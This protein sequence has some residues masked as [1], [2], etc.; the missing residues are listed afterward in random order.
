MGRLLKEECPSIP[1]ANE[2]NK[3]SPTYR[4]RW[5]RESST[6]IQWSPISEPSARC[7]ASRLEGTPKWSTE[8][9]HKEFRKSVSCEFQG[10]LITKTRALCDKAICTCCNQRTLGHSNRKVW[11]RKRSKDTERQQPPKHSKLLSI[12]LLHRKHWQSYLPWPCRNQ[13]TITGG[14]GCNLPLLQGRQLYSAWK[15]KEPTRPGQKHRCAWAVSTLCWLPVELPQ[16]TFPSLTPRAQQENG[17]HA[18]SKRQI[19][20]NDL[21]SSLCSPVISSLHVIK[22]VQQE[23]TIPSALPGGCWS[24]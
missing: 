3:K 12:L 18:T 7:A 9:N 4:L 14:Q 11:S 23:P 6:A 10:S 15:R 1:K 8:F 2:L 20:P 22:P 13:G 16:H 24:H 21:N 5:P 19:Q 17:L